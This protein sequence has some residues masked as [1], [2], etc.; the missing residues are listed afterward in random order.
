[1]STRNEHSQVLSIT[2]WEN[3]QKCGGK[4]SLRT[5]HLTDQ[6][7]TT[8]RSPPQ[9]IWLVRSPWHLWTFIVKFKLLSERHK[10]PI[11]VNFKIHPLSVAQ[12]AQWAARWL[13]PRPLAVQYLL[14]LQAHPLGGIPA[15]TLTGRGQDA[16]CN[17]WGK[18]GRDRSRLQRERERR[19]KTWTSDEQYHPE[20][21]ASLKGA[22]GACRSIHS[23]QHI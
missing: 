4:W 16:L 20:A 10:N 12:E 6:P 3:W 8:I 17:C 19:E 18:V 22:H 11:P 23:F 15:L 14:L 21:R 7:F 1:M 13:W 9:D 5:Y 2:S